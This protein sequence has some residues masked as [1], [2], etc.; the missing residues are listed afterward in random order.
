MS[1]NRQ[2]GAGDPAM[3]SDTDEAQAAQRRRSK[4]IPALYI[5]LGFLLLAGI[6]RIYF[7]I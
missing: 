3:L 2:S 5:F 4:Q 1:D 6:Y 7:W